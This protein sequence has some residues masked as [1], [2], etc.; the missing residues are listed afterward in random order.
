V[1]AKAAVYYGV[2]VGDAGCRPPLSSL[3]KAPG[4]VHLGG[5]AYVPPGHREDGSGGAFSKR[6]KARTKPAAALSPAMCGYASEGRRRP[7]PPAPR[8]A[9]RRS[10]EGSG[11]SAELTHIASICALPTPRRTLVLATP[12]RPPPAGPF[13]SIPCTS[14][15][16]GAGGWCAGGGGVPPGPPGG[17]APSPGM[18]VVG[19]PRPLWFCNVLGPVPGGDVMAKGPQGRV[20]CEDHVGRRTTS[21]ATT[22]K[23]TL[24]A[25]HDSRG[26][27]RGRPGGVQPGPARVGLLGLQ[28]SARALF[29]A[30]PLKIK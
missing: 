2:G 10:R 8:G 27:R 26:P 19:S 12:G 7:D 29:R 22:T 16:G 14:G 11:C 13:V 21:P 23:I 15:A 24:A 20:Q 25:H 18:F 9:P 3:R 28:C 6:K 30:A 5:L 17:Q 4:A 1:V